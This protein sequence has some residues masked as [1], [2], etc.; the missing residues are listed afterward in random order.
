MFGAIIMLPLYLQIV[1]GAT[2]TEAGLKLIPLMLGILSVTITSGR[3]ITKTGKYRIFPILGTI[4]MSLGLLFMT[5]LSVDTPYWQLSIYSI[6]VGAGLGASMQTIVIALQNAVDFKDLG[7]A[8]S[9]NTFFRS[10]GGAFGTAIFGTILSH[11]VTKN[12][13][14]GFQNLA[15]TN[16]GQLANLDPGLIGTLQ[17]NTEAIATLPAPV[18]ST[19]LESFMGAFHTVFW[20][21]F[22]VVLIGFVFA[23][24]LKEK[25]LQSS[26][27]HASARQDAAGES[28]G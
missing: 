20:A 10:L 6:I 13:E 11:Q 21:A 19:V 14:S 8:T 1:Q 7:I 4:T 2:A 24:F 16:P 9:S 18:Q 17:N 23:L 22:P 26:T 5:T 25:P 28:M 3:V 27:E 12:L 15:A